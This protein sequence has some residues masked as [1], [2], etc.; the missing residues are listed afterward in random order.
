MYF[1]KEIIG[2]EVYNLYKQEEK[3]DADID[4]RV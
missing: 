2:L 1:S 3:S 4:S